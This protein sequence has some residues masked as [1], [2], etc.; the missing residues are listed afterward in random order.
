MHTLMISREISLLFIRGKTSLVRHKKEGTGLLNII[1]SVVNLMLN[2]YREGYFM[3][4]YG[5]HCSSFRLK[6]HLLFFVLKIFKVFYKELYPA[7]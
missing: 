2:L 1:S 5:S 3:Q 6:F 7:T 4:K